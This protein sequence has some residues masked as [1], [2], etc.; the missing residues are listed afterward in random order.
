MKGRTKKGQ[1]QKGHKLFLG[2]NNHNWK[3]ENVQYRSLHERMYKEVI[4]PKKC[5][6]CK[7]KV[8]L[9]LANISQK[10]KYNKYDWMWLCREC[11]LRYDHQWIFK[12][13]KW[14]KVCKRC[15]IE[16]EVNRENFYKLKL[17]GFLPKCKK[18]TYKIMNECRKKKTKTGGRVC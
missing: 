14:Y 8:Q 7:E 9:E 5:T 10:Y 1:F 15:K 3:G 11:H 16:L 17:G 13:N 6:F 4:K 12:E 18:C 2:E